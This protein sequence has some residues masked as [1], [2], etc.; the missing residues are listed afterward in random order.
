MKNLQEKMVRA[1]GFLPLHFF[2]TTK[3]KT[4]KRKK[5]LI[6]SIAADDAAKQQKSNGI[7]K[8]RA[9]RSVFLEPSHY[10]LELLLS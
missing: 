10:F 3:G 9:F 5:S 2:F 7:L 1:L 6:S 8:A 4:E